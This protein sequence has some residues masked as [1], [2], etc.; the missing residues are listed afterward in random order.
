MGDQCRHLGAVLVRARLEGQ[1]LVRV[2]PL[3]RVPQGLADAGVVHG[4]PGDDRPVVV[5]LPDDRTGVARVE[6]T[7]VLDPVRHR[8]GLVERGQPVPV[9]HV[10][11]ASGRPGRQMITQ[12]PFQLEVSLVSLLV[13]QHL[14]A[15]RIG[16]L[17]MDHGEQRRPGGRALEAELGHEPGRVVAVVGVVELVPDVPDV[18]GAAAEVVGVVV[19]GVGERATGGVGPRRVQL[20][21]DGRQQ[22]GVVPVTPAATGQLLAPAPLDVAPDVLVVA[23]P[24]RQAGSGESRV[25]ASRASATTSLRSGSSSL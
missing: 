11:A 13:D 3:Q 17:I 4:G 7:E 5:Q 24:H 22:L 20:G 10:G 14:G 1:Q 25:T 15:V 8:A 9:V 12:T 18:H 21:H 16:R 23:V 19:V 2:H 6:A